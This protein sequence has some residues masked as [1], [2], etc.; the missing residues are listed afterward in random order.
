MPGITIPLGGSRP[1]PARFPRRGTERAGR[2][3]QCDVGKDFFIWI[4]CNP[5]KSPD[6]DELLPEISDFNGLWDGEG[7]NHPIDR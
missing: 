7:K 2:V 6:S 5:L 3:T 4:H 1:R